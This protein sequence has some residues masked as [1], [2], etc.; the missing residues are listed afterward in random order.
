[1]RKAGKILLFTLTFILLLL[2]AAISFTVGWRPF[3]GARARPTTSKTFE[4]TPERLA[5]GRYLVTGLVG[6]ELCHTLKDWNTHGAPNVSDKELA[7]QVLPVPGLPGRIVASNLTPDVET[8]G[9]S[10]SDDQF[11]R[12]IREGIGHDGR[13]IFPMMPY[14]AYRQIADEDLAS[15]VVYLRSVPP[16]R[17]L[18]PPTEVS[19][20]VNYLV[21][22]APEPVTEPVSGPGPQADP[23]TRGK[24]LAAIGCGCH[25]AADQKG[26]I[27]G[28]EYGGGE[29]LK[30]PW[31]EV[32]SPNITS[33]PTGISYYDDALFIRALRTGYVNARKLSSIMPFG[34]FANLTNDDLKAILAYLQTLP[35][36]K[37]RVDNSLPPTY[38]KV[39]RQKHGAGDNN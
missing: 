19:F 3:I 14:S 34:E 12:A 25:V 13:T 17:N 10:W 20:P 26:P 21:R 22:N 28:L 11:A 27:P 6:C 16:V 2:V 33:D 32:T 18:L 4:R 7:G 5:R 15:I 35:P 24:Y 39:C 8:G 23:V 31:G 29:S 36:V 9:G 1:M 38:C 30:G 37:H